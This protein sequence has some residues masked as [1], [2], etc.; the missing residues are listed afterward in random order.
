MPDIG[1]ELSDLK[2]RVMAL[3]AD[4]HVATATNEGKKIFADGLAEVSARVKKLEA[5]VDLA[6]DVA[7]I[8][9]SLKRLEGTVSD[10]AEHFTAE[11]KNVAEAGPAAA[12]APAP[13]GTVGD[14]GAKGAKS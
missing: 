7:A 2:R 9:E 3:E 4:P 11:L 13:G 1:Q 10:W 8:K 6:G 5:K 12:V 14:A